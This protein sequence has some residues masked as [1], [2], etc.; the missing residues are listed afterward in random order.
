MTD[1]LNLLD[2]FPLSYETIN[3]CTHT[4]TCTRDHELICNDCGDVLLNLKSEHE[5]ADDNL[6]QAKLYPYGHDDY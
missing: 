2:L 5:H 3:F 6:R 4:R 1:P